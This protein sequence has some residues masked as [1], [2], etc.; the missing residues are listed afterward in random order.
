MRNRVAASFNYRKAAARGYSSR[1]CK[2]G[3]LR[4]YCGGP[5]PP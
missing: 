1:A 2:V 4:R 3:V 5:P